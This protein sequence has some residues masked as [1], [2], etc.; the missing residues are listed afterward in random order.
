MMM[1]QL[2][3]VLPSFWIASYIGQHFGA[4]Y[5][6]DAY[7]IAQLIGNLFIL[8]L[9]EGIYRALETLLPHYIHRNDIIQS[10][11]QRSMALG[12][13]LL[14]IVILVISYGMKSTLE[15]LGIDPIISVHANQWLYIYF[16]TLPIH[17]MNQL[18]FIHLSV[19]NMVTILTVVCLIG[20]II[21]LP[22]L[23]SLFGTTFGFI[24]TSIALFCHEFHLVMYDVILYDIIPCEEKERYNANIVTL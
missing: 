14:L 15:Y 6:L 23:L 7:T 10:I 21:V 20:T 11:L 2:A 3:S 1:I 5:Y 18:L 24:G 13:L 17:Y 19:Q 4:T 16:I 8:T 22:M 9:W 12:L